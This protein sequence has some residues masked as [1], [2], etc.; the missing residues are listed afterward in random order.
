MNSAYTGNDASSRYFFT[1]I[2]FMASQRGELQERRIRVNERR[3]TTNLA[4]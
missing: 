1:G 3:N 2:D 4:D